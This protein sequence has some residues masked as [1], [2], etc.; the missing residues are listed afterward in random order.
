MPMTRRYFLQQ[1]AAAAVALTTVPSVFAD[2]LGLPIGLPDLSC[3]RLHQSGRNPGTG[4]T[5]PRLGTT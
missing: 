4:R 2:P 1:G 5:I 3:P